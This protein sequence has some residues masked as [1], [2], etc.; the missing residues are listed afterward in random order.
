MRSDQRVDEGVFQWFNHVERI[1]NDRIA[2][3]VYVGEASKEN[4]PG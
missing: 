4:D 2:K 1:K 3:K